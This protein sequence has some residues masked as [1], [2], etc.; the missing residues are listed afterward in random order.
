MSPF[1]QVI[2]FI[3]GKLNEEDID[4]KLINGLPTHY[5]LQMCTNVDELNIYLN[6]YFNNYGVIKLS[7]MDLIQFLRKIFTQIPNSKYRN[8]FFPKKPSKNETLKNFHEK[9]PWLKKEEIQMLYDE[10]LD[11]EEKSMVDETF[12]PTFKNK[13]RKSRKKK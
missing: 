10:L 9:Y 12:D 8:W 7:T 11:K 6:E 1:T 4:E 13:T 2:Y 3:T 5:I